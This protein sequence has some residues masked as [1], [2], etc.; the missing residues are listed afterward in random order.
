M[1]PEDQPAASRARSRHPIRNVC[2]L[3][4]HDRRV[5]LHS[6][7]TSSILVCSSVPCVSSADVAGAVSKTGAVCVYSRHALGP[8]TKAGYPTAQFWGAGLMA[9]GETKRTKGSTTNHHG[10]LKNVGV[11]EGGRN[12]SAARQGPQATRGSQLRTARM[13]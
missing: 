11:S 3:C 6:R 7:D 12:S 2:R 9:H 8:A 5:G 10:I 1:S 4:T 13:H